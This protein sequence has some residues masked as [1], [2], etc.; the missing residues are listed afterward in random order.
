[1]KY[2]L[3]VSTSY[4]AIDL[5]LHIPLSMPDSLQ[6][7]TACL[8]VDRDCGIQSGTWAGGAGHLE[9]EP[10]S[11]HSFI[12]NQESV[13]ADVQAST[14]KQM[15][16]MNQEQRGQPTNDAQTNVKPEYPHRYPSQALDHLAGGCT[17]HLIGPPP[18]RTLTRPFSPSPHEHGRSPEVQP[19][20]W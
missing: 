7:L 13:Q 10:A 19:T 17:L 14:L 20:A 12:L 3:F 8:C 6:S 4:R 16:A 15:S 5:R 11:E 9:L 18:P 2:R 1:M